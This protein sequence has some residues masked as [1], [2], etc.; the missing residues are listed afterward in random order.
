ML[1][2]FGVGQTE[3]F[4]VGLICCFLVVPIIVAVAVVAFVAANK[5]SREKRDS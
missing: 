4:I 3:L 5:G 2:V 1:A